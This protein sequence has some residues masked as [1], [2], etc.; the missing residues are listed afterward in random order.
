MTLFVGESKAIKSVTAYYEIKGFGVPIPLGDCDYVSD[1]TGVVIVSDVGLVTAVEADTATITVT[2]KGETDKI[3]VTVSEPV[4]KTIT[5]RWLE[6]AV[7]YY[8]D[9]S[10]IPDKSWTNDPIPPLV[11]GELLPPATLI[12]DDGGYHFADIKEYYNIWA[13]PDTEG[14]IVISGAGEL[15]GYAT[16]TYPSATPL[17]T[18]DN[19]VGQVGIIFDETIDWSEVYDGN[20]LWGGEDPGDYDGVMVG[21]YTQWSYKFGTEEDV[22]GQYE[23]A[24]KCEGFD[25]KW[26]VGYTNYI[27]HGGK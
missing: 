11:E 2:Y 24:I 8:P 1:P 23:N 10:E 7:R 22:L 4:V 18:E 13:S 27:A 9:G 12:Q 16:Y 5:I 17:P 6:D 3:T 20:E 15:S 25:D 26:L 21:T 19:F 14:S